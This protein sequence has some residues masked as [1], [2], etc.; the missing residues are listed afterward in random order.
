MLRRGAAAAA[1]HPSENTDLAI[2]TRNLLTHLGSP[3]DEVALP[4]VAAAVDTGGK[5][6]V[7][8]LPALLEELVKTERSYLSRIRAL[9]SVSQCLTLL[10]VRIR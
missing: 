5:G 6:D 1:E 7:A 10:F 3:L 8:R 2:E 4:E 9:K